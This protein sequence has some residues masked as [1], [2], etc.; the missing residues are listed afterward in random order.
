MWGR[1]QC[2]LG[3]IPI[4]VRLKL[5]EPLWFCG[6]C[7]FSGV[8]CAVLCCA[9]VDVMSA[10]GYSM[11]CAVWNVAVVSMPFWLQNHLSCLHEC[12]MRVACSAIPSDVYFLNVCVRELRYVVLGWLMDS[13]LWSHSQM[14]F[15]LIW[16]LMQSYFDPPVIKDANLQPRTGSL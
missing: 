7:Y 5:F 4:N 6:C 2:I 11:W 14:W 15:F 16:G 13:G 12:R 10:G 9:M 8:C 1:P 3:T